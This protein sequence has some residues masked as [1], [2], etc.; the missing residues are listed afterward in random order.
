MDEIHIDDT[1]DDDDDRG[2]VGE[3]AQNPDEIQIDLD[4]DAEGDGLELQASGVK[5]E[6][7]ANP[8]GSVIDHM[9]RGEDDGVGAP[10][11]LEEL[12]TKLEIPTDSEA[13]QPVDS[14]D[15]MTETTASSSPA[16]TLLSLTRFLGLDKC[17]PNRDFLQ[18]CILVLV[19]G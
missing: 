16:A 6:T 10:A 17:L 19:R 12:P 2:V 7:G 5:G 11:E 13:T 1:V 8:D 9:D 18:A 15:T 3:G 14:L 4:E